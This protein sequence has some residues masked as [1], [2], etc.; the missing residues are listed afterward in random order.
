MPNQY[1]G[2]TTVEAKRL[3]ITTGFNRL[4]ASTKNWF[5]ILAKGFLSPITLML[6]AA[7][8]LSTIA[9]ELVNLAVILFLTL[10]NISIGWW[11]ERKADN[12]L[13]Q[14]Q[15][16]LTVFVSTLRDDKW[17]LID[18]SELVLGDV[19]KLK[20]G[21]VVPADLQ[22]LISENLT[23]NESVLTGESLPKDKKVGDKAYSGSYVATGAGVGRVEATGIKTF[24]GRTL[25]TVES[26]ARISALEKDIL[27]IAKL[28]S[29][30]S[31]VVVAGLTLWLIYQHTPFLELATLDLSLLIAGI[32]VALP[33][34]M[35]LSLVL[36]F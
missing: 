29:L 15:K 12:S 13:K 5:K 31:L 17:Q 33:T 20:V 32:P 35:S 21:N 14:L 6:L 3:L 34:V 19:V 25:T 7:A 30:V 11:H 4:P 8:A 24:F 18:S 26:R 28:V 23:I 27:S 16:Q 1:K 10:A 22:L 36:G 9:G 2:L